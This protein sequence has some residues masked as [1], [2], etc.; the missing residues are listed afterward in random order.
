MVWVS[1]MFLSGI[2]SCYTKG[3]FGAAPRTAPGAILAEA[4]P[5]TCIRG[6]LLV[7]QMREQELFLHCKRRSGRLKKPTSPAP[8]PALPC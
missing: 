7:G 1:S 6:V 4:V 2:L 5:K 8:T 3:L